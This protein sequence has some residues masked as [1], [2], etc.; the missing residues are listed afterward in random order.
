MTLLNQIYHVTGIFT[1]VLLLAYI[2]DKLRE[3][4]REIKKI[5]EERNGK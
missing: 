2:C 4:C 1:G 5:R 3:I